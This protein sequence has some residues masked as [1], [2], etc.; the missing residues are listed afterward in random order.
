MKNSVRLYQ[1][2][3]A[4]VNRARLPEPNKGE[5]KGRKNDIV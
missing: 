2:M 5:D 4:W 3:E 1:V